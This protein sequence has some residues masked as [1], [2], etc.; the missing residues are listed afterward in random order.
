MDDVDI[1][2]F[3]YES[4]EEAKFSSEEQVK[5]KHVQFATKNS[6]IPATFTDTLSNA[7]ISSE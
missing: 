5:S 7:S 1:S 3:E 2:S 4:E 6:S